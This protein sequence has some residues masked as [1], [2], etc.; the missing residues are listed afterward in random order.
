M[1]NVFS[2]AII[3]CGLMLAMA[4]CKKDETQAVLTPGAA[5][6]LTAS[7]TTATLVKTNASAPAVTYTWQPADF[8][9]QAAVKYTLQFAK[10]GT[11]FAG[12]KTEVVIP[13]GSAPSRS[14]T[15][16]QLNSVYGSLDCNIAGTNTR[17][18][19]RLKAMVADN[20]APIYSNLGSITA[21]PYQSQTPPADSWAI[22][23]S[24]TAKGWNDDTPM[25]YDYC[26]NVWKITIPLT[27]TAGAN[28]FKFRA[29]SGWAVNLGDDGADGKLEAG[30]ANITSPG[31][32][33]Y[34][35]TLDLS[36]SPKPTYTIKLH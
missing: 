20:V 30:G 22:I 9:Y 33:I 26:K 1:H 11:N 27:G 36:A 21:T 2:K 19:V 15:V 28:E 5:P 17:L 14:F 6:Q 31:T 7:A 3:A 8:G 18:D 13:D 16:D 10:Q 29:N 23:G 12:V 34:D 4:S 35:V 24:A 25:M 32:G